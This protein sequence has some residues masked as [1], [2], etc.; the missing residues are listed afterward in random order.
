MEVIVAEFWAYPIWGKD[1][2]TLT[3]LVNWMHDA[4]FDLYDFA[5]LVARRRDNRLRGG[6]VIF[7]RRGSPLLADVS[8]D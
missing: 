2:T 1:M 3:G 8:W 7:V 4:G 6:D 5:A